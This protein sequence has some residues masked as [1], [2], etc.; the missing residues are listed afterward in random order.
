VCG[1]E[2]AKK[3][4]MPWLSSAI[5]IAG[6]LGLLLAC[7]AGWSLHSDNVRAAQGSA[8]VAILIG[9]LA[10]ALGALWL[11][12]AVFWPLESAGSSSD[13]MLLRLPIRAVGICLS[14]AVV[15]V[16]IAMLV[17]LAA[18]RRSTP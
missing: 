13:P 4:V 1:A 10:V 7:A 16:P 2:V 17:L 5:A 9:C 8:R 3:M 11:S 14:L 15:E 18:R 12:S 6:A